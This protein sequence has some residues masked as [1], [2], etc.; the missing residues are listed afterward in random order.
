MRTWRNID[1]TDWPR[2]E[3]DN[4]PDKAHWIDPD[5]GL[6]CLV[7]RVPHHGALCGYVGVP[8]SHPLFGK[9]EYGIDVDVHG[10][11]TF[12]G[13]CGSQEDEGKGICHPKEGA[14]NETVWWLGFDC[15]HFRDLNPARRNYGEE[16]YRDFP[17]VQREV[18]NLARQLNE[19]QTS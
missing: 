7:V 17:Y 4:E 2:G 3:W 19:Q 12:S 9:D 11:L 6:D 10:G 18:T 15:I 8:E 1:K 16:E 13:R 14:A 5:T